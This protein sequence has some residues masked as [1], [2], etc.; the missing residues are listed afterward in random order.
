MFLHRLTLFV[1]LL[2][3]GSSPTF[4]KPKPSVIAVEVAVGPAQI[5]PGGF[6]EA[7]VKVENV[8]DKP[9]TVIL[10]AAIEY[11][12]GT[13]D[14]LIN[15]IRRGAITIEPGQGFIV[16]LLFFVPAETAAGEA[17]FTATAKVVDVDGQG[18]GSVEK[19][20]GDSASFEVI[21]L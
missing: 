18:N 6:G 10:D 2:C 12:D 1:I 21:D 19:R 15:L 8:T 17:T 16:S 4:A 11:A 14:R 9:V 3:L 20:V 7:E 13:N 5:A